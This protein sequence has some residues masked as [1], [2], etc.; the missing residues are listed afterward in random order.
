MFRTEALPDTPSPMGPA[1]TVIFWLSGMR[2]APA[3]LSR[4]WKTQQMVE[5]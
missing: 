5:A 4:N 1:P 2:F 3:P